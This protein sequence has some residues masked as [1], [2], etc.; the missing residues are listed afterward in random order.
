[1]K[2]IDLLREQRIPFEQEGDK[3]CRPGW[4]QLVCPFCG[5]GS[6]KHHL[7]YNLKKNYLNCWKCGAHSVASTLM[8]IT[9]QSY[10]EVKVLMDGL[11]TDNAIREI[12]ERRGRLQLPVGV[13]PLLGVHRQYL[14]G[15]GYDPDAIAKEWGIQGIGL[16]PELKWRLF[17]PF[18]SRGEVVSW[19]TRSIA[20]NST[21]RYISAAPEQEA[22]NHK[23]LLYGEDKARHA[24]CVVEGP[25]DAWKIG[26]GAVATCGTSY[27]RAQI[28]RMARFPLIGIC[29]DNEP[30]AQARA[31]DLLNQLSA[32]GGEVVN[33]QLD[34]KDP[35]EATAEELDTVRET[36]H[37]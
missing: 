37:L 5:R 36:L 6:A 28:L 30:A 29:F 32:F 25:I 17:I 9:G 4:I 13:G 3:H 22:L 16:Q 19:T 18:Y 20:K 2:F 35:G 34:S 8:E 14:E 27:S 15:R 23:K 7:G 12:I 10:R 24:I 33:I 1:M 26:P 21:Q 31:H 11:E